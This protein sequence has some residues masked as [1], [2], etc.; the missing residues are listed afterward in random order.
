MI[1]SK[2]GKSVNYIHNKKYRTTN[3][4]YSLFLAK[5]YL[6]NS[7]FILINGDIFLSKIYLSK[8]LK[9]KNSTSF[10]IKS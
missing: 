5:K 2:L 9:F 1:E 7:N 10:A 6:Q 4:I 3:S 8:I